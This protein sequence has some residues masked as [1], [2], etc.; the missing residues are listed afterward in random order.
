MYKMATAG[1]LSGTNLAVHLQK[2]L[3]ISNEIRVMQH[4]LHSKSLYDIFS[5]LHRKDSKT[6]SR[7]KKKK[8]KM[9][10][11]RPFFGTHRTQYYALKG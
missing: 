6:D 7:K 3:H 2:C 11:E 8:K 4:F 10:C 9:N 5:D 1:V